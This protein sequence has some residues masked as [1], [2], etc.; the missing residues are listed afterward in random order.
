MKEWRW[1]ISGV[2][3]VACASIWA[4]QSH[5]VSGQ[6]EDGY[7]ALLG[8][9]DGDKDIDALVTAGENTP[10][11][12]ITLW[13]NQGG[14]QGSTQ[15]KFSTS[16][17]H[18]GD[19]G[20]RSTVLGD[21]DKDGDLDV[22]LGKADRFEIFLNTGGPQG[23]W[24]GNF[25][26]PGGLQLLPDGADLQQIVPGDLDADGDLDVLIGGSNSHRTWL[27]DG[28]GQ[29][30]DSYQSFAVAGSRQLALGDLDGDRD[31][32]IVILTESDSASADG[33]PDSGPADQIWLNDGSGRFFDSG[34]RFGQGRS[35]AVALGDLD[36][37]N[38]LDAFILSALNATDETRSIWL[39]DG[40]GRFGLSAS[41]PGRIAAQVIILEDLDQDLDLD[42]LISS[43]E[44]V[45]VWINDGLG[46]FE[47]SDQRIALT[48]NSAVALGDLDGDGDL[49]LFS[50]Y[51][52]QRYRIWWNDGFGRLGLS[53]R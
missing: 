38:D 33:V 22:L 27:N 2:V 29:F 7:Q 26:Q 5:Q 15:G 13:I 19:Q 48:R 39:N 45:E 11:P 44:S 35:L 28:N 9:L 4:V 8:D 36:G 47:L 53:W 20:S 42:V 18:L 17:Q 43:G 21:L 46:A 30:A 23:G 6:P 31:P 25:Q 52:N 3:L 14:L 1:L 50:G 34:Q 24:Q 37:D 10:N 40:S 12:A 51:L 16:L 41:L 49:D 32:D